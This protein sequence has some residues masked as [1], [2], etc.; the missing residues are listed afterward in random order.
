MR[1]VGPEPKL[2][3]TIGAR[4]L[5]ALAVNPLHVFAIRRVIGWPGVRALTCLTVLDWWVL[6]AHVVPLCVCGS[7]ALGSQRVA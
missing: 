6:F 7:A 3:P 1:R 2:L 4:D 5:A